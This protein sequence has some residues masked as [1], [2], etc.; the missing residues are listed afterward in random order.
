MSGVN[1]GS[2]KYFYGKGK[3]VLPDT[4]WIHPEQTMPRLNHHA[5]CLR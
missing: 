3:L 4:V 5:V 2:T 1:E